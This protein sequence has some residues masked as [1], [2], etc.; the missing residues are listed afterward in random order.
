MEQMLGRVRTY[1]GSDASYGPW[2]GAA[3][4]SVGEAVPVSPTGVQGG[5]VTQVSWD[6]RG[7]TDAAW[8]QIWINKGTTKHWSGW[9]EVGD[10]TPAGNNRTYDLP[11]TITSGSYKWWIQTWNGEY[12]PWSDLDGVG[13][14]VP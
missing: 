12:G 13:F 1:R 3:E 4:F 14:T 5:D 8:Y 6:N 9:V 10:T 7:C 2:T 11:F